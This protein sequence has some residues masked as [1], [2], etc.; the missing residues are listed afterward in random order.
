MYVNKDI[1]FLK[2]LKNR[3]III[4]GAG[5]Q[6]HKTLVNLNRYNI[7]VIAFCDNDVKK[8]NQ[9][10]KG[11]QVISFA[12]LLEINDANTTIVISAFD[13]E[14]KEQLLM[15]NIH[16]FISVSQIDFGG[17]EEY[18]DETY[19]EWQQ[20]MGAFGAKIKV[21][22]F[23][24][25]IGK[26]MTVVEFGS[27]GGYL[28]AEIDAKE[29]I[30]IEINDAARKASEDIG[31]KSV[32]NISDIADDYADIIISTSVLEHTENPLGILR[33]LYGKLK[34]GGKIVFHVPNESCDTEYIKSELHNHLYTWNCLNIGNLFKAAGY[35]VYSVQKVQEVWPKN[36]FEI[37]REVSPELFDTICSI[38]GRAFNE[39][40]CII[41]AYK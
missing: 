3:K 12:E 39:N 28:L 24:P 15:G 31:I 36:F 4:F 5:K 10:I 13:R 2:Y 23:Q 41:V 6:G 38:G 8:H 20:E 9:L 27:G 29:K 19:F 35:F 25:H 33:E 26:E 16:N 11:I 22:M 30:G 14:V 7:G 21:N 40:R 1:N 32:K 37:A 18:Y 34:E 17:G